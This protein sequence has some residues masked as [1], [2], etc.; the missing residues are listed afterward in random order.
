MPRRTGFSGPTEAGDVERQW[1]A[2]IIEQA[3]EGVHRLGDVWLLSQTH[4]LTTVCVCQRVPTGARPDDDPRHQAAPDVK[5]L[6]P[7]G[8][9]DTTQNCSAEAIAWRTQEE[10][11]IPP[12]EIHRKQLSCNVEE[13]LR[14]RTVRAARLDSRAS[15]T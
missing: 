14:G 15:P 10:R 12:A 9:A 4:G 8:Q 3:V 6:S 7:S 5:Q 2:V 11:S 13:L 1:I